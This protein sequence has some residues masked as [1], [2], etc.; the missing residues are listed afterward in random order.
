MNQIIK[1]FEQYLELENRLRKVQPKNDLKADFN[2]IR[3][4]QD[5]NLPEHSRVTAT[6]LRGVP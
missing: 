4:M 6:G 1:E 5:A 3:K 2:I